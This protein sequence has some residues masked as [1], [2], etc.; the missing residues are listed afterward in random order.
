MPS[1]QVVLYELIMKNVLQHI[2]SVCECE[3]Y[4]RVDT[5]ELWF[6]MPQEY[7]FIVAL[8]DL[9]CLYNESEEIPF[10][11]NELDPNRLIKIEFSN[12]QSIRIYVGE[13]V[14]ED[15]GKK[16][17]K[18]YSYI[19]NYVA[20]NLCKTFPNSVM[21]YT[22]KKHCFHEEFLGCPGVKE[23]GS[24]LYVNKNSFNS[25]LVTHTE[26]LFH[27]I[28]QIGVPAFYN[29]NR[30]PIDNHDIRILP[31]NTK[32]RRLGYL[33]LLLSMFS[34][35]D[36]IPISI[37]YSKFETLCVQYKEYLQNYKNNKG[38]IKKTSTG[39]SA[40]PYIELA[41]KLGFLN[42]ITGYYT[43]GKVGKVYNAITDH[44]NIIEEN[45]FTLNSI[46]VP[47]FLELILM[48]DYL[49]ISTILRLLYQES[50]ISYDKIR[51]IFQTELLNQC[52]IYFAREDIS[53][54]SKH[55][56][57]AQI[58]KIKDWK[59]SLTYLEHIIM[60]RINWL[61]DMNII[62]INSN[63]FCLTPIGKRLYVNLTI[64]D[65]IS[66]T[67]IVSPQWQINNYFIKM[68]DT[69]T[70]CRCGIFDITTHKH[71]MKEYIDDA[72]TLFKTLAPNRVTFSQLAQY[73]K[74]MLYYNHNLLVDNADIKELFLGLEFYEYIF[75][76]QNQYNDGYI[77]KK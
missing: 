2:Y 61:Y 55:S 19:T 4:I 40:K 21:S 14:D 39:V 8:F 69:I 49:Y 65:D 47:F 45:I 56:I 59:K 25:D 52:C 48:E 73:V 24:M 6:Q 13:F 50:E 10:Y 12:I 68:Y 31:S 5:N 29:I 43:L 28:Q 51:T 58:L 76:F 75:K 57:R 15:E 9:G 67:K 32:V 71:L 38:E 3:S 41:E 35:V 23:Y 22:T 34:D 16:I 62:S 42:K 11:M 66:M 77:Q 17:S 44:V 33:K 20:N 26:T 74:Y 27:N 54:I 30:E 46:D 72:F 64:W 1:A 7:W 18:P 37:I 60:P 36:K 70:D 53:F 63:S